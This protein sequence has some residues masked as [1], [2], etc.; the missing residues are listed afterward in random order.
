MLPIF[1]DSNS[2]V[3]YHILELLPTIEEALYHMQVQLGEL[4]LEESA[5]LFQDTAEAIASI[6][7]CVLPMI[8]QDNDQHLLKSIANIRE[9][10]TMIIDAYEQSDLAAIQTALTNR[11]IPSFSSWHQELI[12]ILRPSVLS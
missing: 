1:S 7:N 10:I 3:I 5:V 2:E 4:R 6:V 9:G 8:N 12:Y 11:L